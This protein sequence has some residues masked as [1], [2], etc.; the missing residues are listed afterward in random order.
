MKQCDDDT[1]LAAISKDVAYIMGQE[2]LATGEMSK[3]ELVLKPVTILQTKVERLTAERDR[4]LLGEAA[5]AQRETNIR[6]AV[7][8]HRQSVSRFVRSFG[9]IN[10]MRRVQLGWAFLQVGSTRSRGVPS[11]RTKKTPGMASVVSDSPS[12]GGSLPCEEVALRTGGR[13]VRR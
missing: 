12:S 7:A 4:V 2:K 6:A 1:V 8:T 9:D 10:S 13:P 11:S 3:D 5:A